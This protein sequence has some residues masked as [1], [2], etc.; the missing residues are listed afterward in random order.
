MIPYRYTDFAPWYE[1]AY[2]DQKK[3]VKAARSFE[4]VHEP[5]SD[6][7]VLIIHGYTG[8][9]GENVRPAR[10]LYQAGFDVFVPRLP[11]HGTCA[12][13]FRK[14]RYTD[15]IKVIDN[16]TVDLLSRYKELYLV[17]HSMGAGIATIVGKMHS[18]V[19]RIVLA[20]PAMSDTPWHLP[21]P[22]FVVKFVSLFLKKWPIKWHS[23]PEYVMYYEDAPADDEYL[24]SEYWKWIYPPMIVNLYKVMLQG[25][26]DI[27]DLEMP[28]LTISGG[29]DQITGGTRISDF[30]MRDKKKGIMRHTHIENA[31]HYLFYD[32]DKDAEEE[33]VR[34]VVDFLTKDESSL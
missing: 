31:T 21:S 16:A 20:A 18:E 25:G 13:D 9:P 17:G 30:I 29:K 8:Y 33:A 7:A 34:A 5:K 2:K 28:V 1:G 14:S 15:W 32:K 6:R 27:M 19:K 11:G 26:K 22:P 12:K 23:D 3:E 24:G 10:D 4:I